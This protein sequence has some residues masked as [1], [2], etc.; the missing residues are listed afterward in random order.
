[1]PRM[2]DRHR[3]QQPAGGN[4]V[5]IFGRRKPEPPDSD[6]GTAVWA[7][8]LDSAS[9]MAIV[10]GRLPVER[11]S[12]LAE[13]RKS[14]LE[15]ARQLAEAGVPSHALTETVRP[16]YD[17]TAVLSECAT[18]VKGERAMERLSGEKSGRRR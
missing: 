4:E 11:A 18:R 5:T 9:R 16:I 17:S 12:V 8:A 10:I 3:D 15:A 13:T 2:G 1:M 7:T 6:L 14:L